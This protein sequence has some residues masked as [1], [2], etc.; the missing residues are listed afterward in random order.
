MNY[1]QLRDYSLQCSLEHHLCNVEEL[2]EA[3]KTPDDILDMV[4]AGDEAL[5]IYEAYEYYDSLQLND[6]SLA[7]SIDVIKT[8]KSALAKIVE[9]IIIIEREDSLQ[10]I[11]AMAPSERMVL[12]KK[13]FVLPKVFIVILLW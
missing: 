4:E 13:T 10:T 11:A 12:I 6:T 7:S 1:E 2:M 8:K 5:I 9:K 3:G